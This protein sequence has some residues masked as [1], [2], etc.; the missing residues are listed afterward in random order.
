MIQSGL[1]AKTGDTIPYVICKGESKTMAQRAHHKDD[2]AKDPT[3]QVDYD[4]YLSNQIHPVIARLCHPIEGTDTARI[5]QSL[6][7]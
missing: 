1:T 7:E 5:A 6:G 3:L 2:F 4:W